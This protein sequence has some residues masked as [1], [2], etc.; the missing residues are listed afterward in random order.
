V[1]SEAYFQ[2]PDKAL[3]AQADQDEQLGFGPGE[4]L[5]FLTPVALYVTSEVVQFLVTEVQKTAREEG[6][7]LIRDRVRRLFAKLRPA[8]SDEPD[9]ARLTQEQLAAVRRL[10]FEKARSAHLS[11][12]QAGLLADALVGS[13]AVA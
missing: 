5:P 13:L 2:N 8:A 1:H 10:A 6:G 9:P 7:E 4:I 12:D 3:H 11:E